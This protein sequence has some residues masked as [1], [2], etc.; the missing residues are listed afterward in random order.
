MGSI[1]VV[2]G[3]MRVSVVSVRCKG[4]GRVRVGRGFMKEWRVM[5]WRR[6]V[7]GLVIRSWS[8]GF[9]G[10]RKGVIVVRVLRLVELLF[11]SLVNAGA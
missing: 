3:V 5:S 10:V 9:I 2:K 4:E 6:R 8:V 11:G 1:R 7:A